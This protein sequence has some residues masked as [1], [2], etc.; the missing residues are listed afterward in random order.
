[1]RG[2]RSS[3]KKQ[4]LRHDLSD[5]EGQPSRRSQKKEAAKIRSADRE[6]RSAGN[7]PWGS[8]GQIT[9]NR[10]TPT[11]LTQE[12]AQ[13]SPDSE[14]PGR[15][16]A[17]NAARTAQ[18]SPDS[19]QQITQRNSELASSMEQ[20]RIRELE[21]DL[22]IAQAAV[23][24]ERALVRQL[25]AHLNTADLCAAGLAEQN[26]QM[27]ARVTALEKLAAAAV[28][29]AT[30]AEASATAAVAREAT[31][32]QQLDWS[33]WQKTVSAPAGAPL[34]QAS[35]ASVTGGTQRQQE[36]QK[37]QRATATAAGA[38][39]A[40]A[41]QEKKAQRAVSAAPTRAQS[42]FTAHMVRAARQAAEPATAL[43]SR[44]AA[45]RCFIVSATKR[46]L[47]PL[48][49]LKGLDLTTA[50]SKLITETLGLSAEEQVHVLDV[51]PIG[52]P[53]R[54]SDTPARRGRLFIRVDR[55]AEADSIVRNRCK[56]KGSQLAIF[57]HLS[58]DELA[59]HRQLWSTFIA[60]RKK[61][62]SAQFQRAKL[63]VKVCKN[64][65]VT[66]Y[67]IHV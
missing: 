58:P 11:D 29:R 38:A 55:L 14:Q 35:Y 37:Q 24:V 6:A 51:T 66:P 17:R 27:D 59:A 52:R 8:R 40:A 7:R 31:W 15:R 47:A 25:E 34:R 57:D 10:G 2:T 36:K 67:E 16:A 60:A 4:K 64:G 61:G 63:V 42:Q 39:A 30:A 19:E 12:Q 21:S 18:S 49:G 54:P 62:Y 20:A 48:V 26:K 50:A 22:F 32:Q 56:L 41:K 65:V 5:I 44:M 28:A 46:Q 1:M 53:L 33:K 3:A 45:K 43:A 13:R 23:E 9:T